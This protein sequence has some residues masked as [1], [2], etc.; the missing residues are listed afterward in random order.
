MLHA[1][2][3]IHAEHDERVHTEL[4]QRQIEIG[5]EESVVA[6]LGHDDVGR[7]QVEIRERLGGF[8]AC[9]TVVAPELEFRIEAGIMRI[10]GEDDGNALRARRLHDAHRIRRRRFRAGRRPFAPAEDIHHD[11]SATSQVDLVG[12]LP[13]RLLRHRYVCHCSFSLSKFPIELFEPFG[14]PGTGKEAGTAGPKP[15]EGRRSVAVRAFPSTRTTPH[16]RRH[17]ADPPSGWP[18]TACQASSTEDPRSHPSTR[19]NSPLPM[20]SSV[21][22]MQ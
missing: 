21:A 6:A 15:P 13:W 3:G 18:L 20:P 5:L 19:E 9:D 1:D 10:V 14:H 2:V 22:A 17:E 11:H 7:L 8:A 12:L 16:R 4:A